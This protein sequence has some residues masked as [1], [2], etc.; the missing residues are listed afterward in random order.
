MR[1]AKN[2]HGLVLVLFLVYL[3]PACQGEDQPEPVR[4]PTVEERIS[5]AGNT[6]NEKERYRLLE[7]LR[8]LDGLDPDL[9]LD[10]DTLLPVIDRWANGR[11][12]YWV[13][14]D[15]PLSAE[16]GYLC[17]FFGLRT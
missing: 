1:N 4:E 7:E 6:E 10:L 15:K 3:F 2:V 5:Q 17:E 9:A 12:K 16:N 13:P 11:E 8:A 14:G